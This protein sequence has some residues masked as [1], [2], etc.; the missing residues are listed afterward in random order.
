MSDNQHEKRGKDDASLPPLWVGIDPG[1]IK[2]GV[3]FINAL[4][5]SPV[6][7]YGVDMNKTAA[8]ADRNLCFVRAIQ[9][10]H[11]MERAVGGGVESQYVGK[12]KQTALAIGRA[13]GWATTML[14]VMGVHEQSLVAPAAWKAG[15]TGNANAS[16]AEYTRI[17][18]IDMQ[19]AGLPALRDTGA[20][21]DKA[22][23]LGVARFT[24]SQW[25]TTEAA[26][27]VLMPYREDIAFTTVQEG[28]R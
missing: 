16:P 5:G 15:Y 25:R 2:A 8:M 7:V 10:M 13:A 3:A 23:A 17:A 1:T 14:H 24:W 20:A 19:S 4:D 18:E 12:N 27:L 22:A 9:M 28:W 21:E 6:A 11:H 26:T